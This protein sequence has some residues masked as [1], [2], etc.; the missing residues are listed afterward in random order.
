MNDEKPILSFAIPTW[1]RAKELSEC[2]DSII[3][4]IIES[5]EN[6]EIV[7]SDNASTDETPKV[8]EEY[9][10]KY[11]FIRYFR[12]EKNVGPDLN[13]I[14]V[15]EKS[16]GKYAWL[17]SDDDW[18]NDGALKE[19]LRIIK[20]YEPC[21]ISTNNYWSE[22]RNGEYFLPKTQIKFSIRKDMI[23]IDSNKVFLYRN[24]WLSFMSTN[25]FCK[26]FMD[27]SDY[28]ANVQSVCYWIQVYMVAQVLNKNFCGY[29]SSYCAV[30]GRIGNNANRWD[31]SLTFL[32][33]MPEEFCFIF[34]KFNVKKTVRKKV[35]NGIRKSFLP[36]KTFLKEKDK[37]G[38]NIS[39]LLIPFYYKLF[40][41][42]PSNFIMFGWK[43]KRMLTGKGFS[44]P[45]NSKTED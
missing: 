1:N 38:E 14:S 34:N 2:L 23:R 12:N 10:K 3:S 13:F 30:I 37:N 39:P 35:I 7:I 31:H 27:L 26:K 25:I 41:V 4:Q 11:N 29:L 18:L 19:I 6:V 22:K 21:Y 20:N 40:S 36:L 44:L 24:H 17:F 33:L 15:I 16:N 43:L 5:N 42:I 45:Q 8:V 9:L 28:K 32:K